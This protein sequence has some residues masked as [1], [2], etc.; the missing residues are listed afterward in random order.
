MKP[1]KSMLGPEGPGMKKVRAKADAI[2][3]T[4]K[5]GRSSRSRLISKYGK[6]INFGK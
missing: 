6:N 2:S 3:S 1:L 4:D 5:A